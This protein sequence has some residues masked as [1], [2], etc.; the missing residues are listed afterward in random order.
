MSGRRIEIRGETFLTLSTVAECFHVQVTW[1]RDVHD[2]GLLGPAER[3]GDELAIPTSALDR[4]AAI[5]RLHRHYG[6]ELDVI[7]VVLER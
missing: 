3:V 6:L 4:V 2:A 7:A 1:L 5:Q